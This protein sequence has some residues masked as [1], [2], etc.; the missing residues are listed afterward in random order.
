MDIVQ[1]T[2]HVPKTAVVAVGVFAVA[3]VTSAMVQP[4]VRSAAH[5]FGYLDHPNEERH[6][7]LHAVPRLGGI[8]VFV[9]LLLTCVAVAVFDSMGHVLHLLPLVLAMAAGAAI[10]FVAGLAD[11]I[12]GVPPIGKL[13]VQTVAALVVYQYG[14]RIEHVILPPGVTFELGMFALPVTVLWIVGLSN[15]FNLVDGADGLAGGVA[16]IALIATAISAGYLGDKTV[17]WSSIALI[18][19]LL[20][21][22]RFNWPP[23]RIFLGDSGSLVVGFLLA[24]LTVKGMSRTDGAVFGLAPIFALSYPLLDTGISMLRRW[25]RGEPLSRADGRHIHHQLQA[26][27]VGPRQ[28]LFV[29]YGLSGLVAMLGLSVTFAPPQLTIA[30]AVAGA[31]MLV[32]ILI[33]GARW[34]QYHEL[35][36]AGAS[37]TS[38]L[39]TARTRV[40]DKINARDV[41]RLVERARTPE[42]LQSVIEHSADRFR[43]VQLQLHWGYARAMPPKGKVSDVEAARLWALDYP[44]KTFR[45]RTEPLFLSVMCSVDGVRAASVERVAEILAT[46]VERWLV[47]HS[48]QVVTSKSFMPE[49]QRMKYGGDSGSL[50]LSRRSGQT[51]AALQLEGSAEIH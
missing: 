23:A 30:I 20:G 22:L 42:E 7:H 44:I 24:V 45:K 26:L 3:Y 34:L 16:I 25:L 49:R 35:L 33:Y 40:Q 36:E 32:L 5:R 12:W 11:D 29:L 21:F 19:A 47:R 8:G 18:G 50:E 13:T 31:A 27:G 2:L 14:F 41:A 43:Y 10:L 17:V 1:D 15:A 4:I 38:A 37:I 46:S 9:A 48:E 39:R 28:S 6:L 51:G